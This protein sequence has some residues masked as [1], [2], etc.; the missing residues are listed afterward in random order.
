MLIQ[1]MNYYEKWTTKSQIYINFINGWLQI[2]NV[3][4]MEII[5]D[6]CPIILW[7]KILPGTQSPL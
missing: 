2:V 3:G 5:M 7:H 1:H 4:A 6:L